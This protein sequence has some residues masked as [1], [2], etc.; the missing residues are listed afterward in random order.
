VRRTRVSFQSTSIATMVTSSV[1]LVRRQA[2]TSCAIASALAPLVQ[3]V[4]QAR[5]AEHL[6]ARVARLDDRGI[7]KD[8]VVRLQ[9]ERI[10]RERCIE[11]AEDHAC[12]ARPCRSAA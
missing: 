4:V 6:V 5:L 9:R 1:S 3:Q 12:T 8:A 10:G 11:S 7:G 2:R